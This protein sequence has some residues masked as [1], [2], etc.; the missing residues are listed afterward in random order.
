V[1]AF[2]RKKKETVVS[3]E[4]EEALQARCSTEEEKGDGG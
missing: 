4:N 3:R 1:H 2:I